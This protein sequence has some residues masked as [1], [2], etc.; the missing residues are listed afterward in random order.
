[1]AEQAQ[2]LV[3]AMAEIS[4]SLR[5]YIESIEFNPKRLE[6]LEERLELLHT[7]K[8]KYGADIPAVLAF[9]G[10][11]RR[12]LDMITHAGERIAELEI[13]E[14]KLLEKLSIAARDLSTK[15][16][17]AAAALSS[18]MERELGDLNMSGAGFA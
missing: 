18:A 1:L 6:E 3:D 10:D 5:T 12:Q 14:T 8:R 16:S 11:A 7:L 4:R 2:G 17:Q 13:K 9:A 15:R